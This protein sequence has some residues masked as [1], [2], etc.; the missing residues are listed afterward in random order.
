VNTALG[1]LLAGLV[2]VALVH[3]RSR[4]IGSFVA[5]TWCAATAVFGAVQ[6]QSRDTLVFLGIGTR[7][8]VFFFFIAG[9]A[10]FNALV[11][12]RMLR[13]KTAGAGKAPR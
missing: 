11:I 1:L 10:F 9:L 6:F 7:P 2:L 12:V 8:W 13:L 3:T 5:L 4:L